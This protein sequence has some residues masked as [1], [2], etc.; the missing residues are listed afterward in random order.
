MGVR[1]HGQEGALA[2]S[3]NVV[4]C[5]CALVVTAK[6]SLDELLMQYLSLSVVSFWELFLRLHHDPPLHPAGELSSRDP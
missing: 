2:P 3:G 6:R 1:W 4:K 5:F